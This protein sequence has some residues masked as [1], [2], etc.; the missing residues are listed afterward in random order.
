MWAG[1]QERMNVQGRDECACSVL[2]G[3][4]WI[5]D[6]HLGQS[7]AILQIHCFFYY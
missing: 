3:A 5:T 6:S 2:P 4:F 1:E 7:V